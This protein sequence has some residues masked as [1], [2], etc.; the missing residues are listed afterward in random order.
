MRDLHYDHDYT[1]RT[2]LVSRVTACDLQRNLQQKLR[3]RRRSGIRRLEGRQH[4]LCHDLMRRSEIHS[5]DEAARLHTVHCAVRMRTGLQTGKAASAGTVVAAVDDRMWRDSWNS[6]DRVRNAEQHA[7]DEVDSI[8]AGIDEAAAASVAVPTCSSWDEGGQGV[9][10][11][12]LPI[13]SDMA[14]AST[15]RSKGTRAFDGVSCDDQGSRVM[16]MK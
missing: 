8:A 16:D 10:R 14:E 3:I 4:G 11:C 5:V 12:W 15:N 6:S 2:R 7:V 1:R 9:T 13:D